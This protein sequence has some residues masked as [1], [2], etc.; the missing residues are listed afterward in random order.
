VVLDELL[1]RLGYDAFVI[2]FGV[3]A[4][5]DDWD[6]NPLCYLDRWVQRASPL[7][8][9]LDVLA[10]PP[11][12]KYPI[13]CD[14]HPF[15]TGVPAG[16]GIE[17]PGVRLTDELVLFPMARYVNDTYEVR[18][19]LLDLDGRVRYHGWRQARQALGYLEVTQAT[20]APRFALPNRRTP[21]LR[22]PSLSQTH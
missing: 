1:Q 10:S 17:A 2:G 18:V 11:L 5:G 14:S 8:R 16:A 20:G 15:T 21:A 19:K 7:D 3:G 13:T 4:Q 6:T 22:L 9:Y 12:T